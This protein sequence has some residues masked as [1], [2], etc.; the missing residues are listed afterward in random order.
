M[1]TSMPFSSI[2]CAKT[3]DWWIRC[4]R[5]AKT[6]KPPV[7]KNFSNDATYQAAWEAYRV[8]VNFQTR[9]GASSGYVFQFSDGGE[10]FR[11]VTESATLN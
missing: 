7:K 2:K 9:N 10:Y 8:A 4:L 3:V 6:W 5:C 11:E 1:T